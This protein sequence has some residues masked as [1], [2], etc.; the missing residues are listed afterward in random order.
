MLEILEGKIT[1]ETLESS[2]QLGG[3]SEEGSLRNSLTSC[4]WND[5]ATVSLVVLHQ[6]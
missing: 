1:Q 5:A 4:S 3:E 2:K 6:I